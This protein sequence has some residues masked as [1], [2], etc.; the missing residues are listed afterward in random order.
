MVLSKESTR[1]NIFFM[2]T[3]L[4][5][6]LVILVLQGERKKKKKKKIEP[7]KSYDL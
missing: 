6:M 7:S 2:T 3:G 5:D 4:H 1:H